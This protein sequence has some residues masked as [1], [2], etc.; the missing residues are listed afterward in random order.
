MAH[1]SNFPSF[2]RCA[3]AAGRLVDRDHVERARLDASSTR[4]W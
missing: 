4:R 3:Q 2:T 1:G